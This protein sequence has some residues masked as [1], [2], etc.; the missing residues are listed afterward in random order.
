MNLAWLEFG[1]ELKFHLKFKGFPG[2]WGALRPKN[3]NLPFKQIILI[4]VTSSH[5]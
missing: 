3:V 2:F 4:F 5:H 1:L